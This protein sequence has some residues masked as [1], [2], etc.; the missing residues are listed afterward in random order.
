MKVETQYYNALVTAFW[1]LT[2]TFY[3]RWKRQC[4]QYVEVGRLLAG[5]NE[6]AM[7]M[8]NIHAKGQGQRSLGSNVTAKTDRQTDRRMGR[9]K[10]G[11]DCITW[12]A[13][14]VNRSYTIP[15]TIGSHA[16]TINALWYSNRKELF[17]IICG[18]VSKYVYQNGTKNTSEDWQMHCSHMRWAPRNYKCRFSKRMNKPNA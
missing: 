17:K 8:T 18:H 2:L 7:V 4:L 15:T 1:P 3:A 11:G 12:V 10:D 14:A 5:K 6:R 9:R 16:S 13:N